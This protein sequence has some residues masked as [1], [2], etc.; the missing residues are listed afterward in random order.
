MKVWP[1]PS[2]A[3][4]VLTLLSSFWHASVSEAFVVPR[5]VRVRTMML[6]AKGF[7]KQPR[8]RKKSG[9]IERQPLSE[10]PGTVPVKVAPSATTY[11]GPQ[12]TGGAVE[13]VVGAVDIEAYGIIIEVGSSVVAPGQLGVFIRL[14]PGKTAVTLPSGLLLCQYAVGEMLESPPQEVS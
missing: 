14:A 2:V 5:S 4:S 13:N 1:V 6:G 7:G 9:D 3:A 8:P 11:V 12:P 10:L